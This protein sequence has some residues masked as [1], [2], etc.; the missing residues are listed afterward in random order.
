MGG[1][2]VYLIGGYIEGVE[3]QSG[4]I[5]LLIT[6]IRFEGLD[7]VTEAHHHRCGYAGV[8]KMVGSHGTIGTVMTA[9]R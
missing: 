2:E 4:N 8:L 5:Q 9:V 3:L 6:A 1:C 7:S